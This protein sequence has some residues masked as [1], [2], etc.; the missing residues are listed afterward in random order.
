MKGKILL[1]RDGVEVSIEIP[2]SRQDLIDVL[3]IHSNYYVKQGSWAFE[4]H[5]ALLN[6]FDL[7]VKI[8]TDDSP[9]FEDSVMFGWYLR[10][11]RL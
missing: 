7:L 4:F 9:S 1:V 5:P 2:E 11:Y 8:I 6:K 3:K 10:H